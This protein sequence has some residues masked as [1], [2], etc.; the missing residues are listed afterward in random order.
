T[1]S[2]SPPPCGEGLGVGV[3]RLHTNIEKCSCAPPR[4]YFT[5]RPPPPPPPHKGGGEI[6]WIERR[7]HPRHYLGRRMGERRDRGLDL[8]AAERIDLEADLGDVR[9]KTF[10]LHSCIEGSGLRLQPV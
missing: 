3:G 6:S 10:V 5:S 4:F 7:A 1:F 9:D 8:L 2:S